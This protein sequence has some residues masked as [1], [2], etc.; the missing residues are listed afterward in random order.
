[1]FLSKS[2]RF[3]LNVFIEI[4]TFSVK[5]FYQ[6]QNVFRLMFLSKSKRFPLN[7]FIEIKKNFPT[8]SSMI[9]QPELGTNNYL[10]L[11][12]W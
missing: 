6:N 7:V 11:M 8:P 9:C 3:P 12:K 10:H 2:K 4:K 5:C 1:M